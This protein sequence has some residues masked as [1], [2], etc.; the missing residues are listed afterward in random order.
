M[1]A[2]A[3]AAEAQHSLL[4]RLGDRAEITDLILEFARCIDDS[5]QAG[6]AATF[7]EECELV[8]PFAHVVGR[9]AIE[10]MPAPQPGMSTHH[11]IANILFD[12]A[13]DVARTRAYLTA[14][15]VFD[16]AR[17]TDIAQAGG[18]YLHDLVRTP[19]GWRFRRVELA[20]VWETAPML[21]TPAPTPA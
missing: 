10:A 1:D 9:A 2:V 15:H 6:Y 14:T 4:R 12:I 16:A 3:A 20:I 11:Q 8:L 13:G 7:D 21:R 17:P 5:D 18:W 19:A